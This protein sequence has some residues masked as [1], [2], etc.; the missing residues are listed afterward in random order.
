MALTPEEQKARRAELEAKDKEAKKKKNQ[1]KL[2]KWQIKQTLKSFQIIENK[3]ALQ[4][5][6]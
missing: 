3:L 1:K 2:E 6:L 5:Q 4:K